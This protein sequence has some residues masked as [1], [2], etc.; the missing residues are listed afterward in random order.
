MRSFCWFCLRRVLFFSVKGDKAVSP[1]PEDCDQHPEWSL[2]LTI[3]VLAGAGVGAGFVSE[4]FVSALEP[5]MEA[6]N[7]SQ[8]F[9]GLVVVAVAG[10]AIEN[11]VG[12]Q[13]R[14]AQSG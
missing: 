1:N 8:A 9:A 6:L 3:G 2:G 7:I 11:I 14:V 13:P 4:W 5:A 12:I 10:N